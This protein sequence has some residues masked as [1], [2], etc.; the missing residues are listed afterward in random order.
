MRLHTRNAYDW[1]LR[2]PTIADAAR[3]IKADTFPIDGEA[4]VGLTACR[5]ATGCDDGRV[6]T[7]R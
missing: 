1:T 5:N 2:L 4:V 7:P 6:C 3:R